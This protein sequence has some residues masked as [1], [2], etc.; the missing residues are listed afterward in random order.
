MTI[1]SSPA[2]APATASGS[3][4]GAACVDSLPFPAGAA[5]RCASAE[6]DGHHRVAGPVQN[7]AYRSTRHHFLVDT[8]GLKASSAHTRWSAP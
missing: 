3:A 4:Q 8:A 5:K 7:P 2:W 6:R 1:T